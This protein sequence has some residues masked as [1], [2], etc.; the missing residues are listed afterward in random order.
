MSKPALILTTLISLVILLS[1][2]RISVANRISTSGLEVKNIED[3]V[4]ALR[5]E[6]LILQEKLLTVS[7]FTQIAS[8]AAKLGFMPAKANL[9]IKFG[10]PV[11]IRQ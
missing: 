11:A 5:K 10:V 3:Q 7:S 8:K 4:A 2:A 9:V 1:I 6:N